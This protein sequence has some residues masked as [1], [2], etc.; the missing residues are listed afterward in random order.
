MIIA[1]VQAPIVAN[2]HLENAR[3]RKTPFAANAMSAGSNW[4]FTFIGAG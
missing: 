4:Q 1:Q 2:T 3:I